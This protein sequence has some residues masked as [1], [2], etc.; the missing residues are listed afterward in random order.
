MIASLK[1]RFDRIETRRHAL[2]VDLMALPADQLAFRPAP[3]AWSLPEVAQHLS[4][5]DGRVTRVLTERRVTGVPRRTLRDVVI[6]ARMLDLFFLTGIRV[7]MPV[8]GVAPDSAVPLERTIEAWAA[9]RVVMAGY[10][11]TLDAPASRTIVYRHPV[12]GFMDIHDTLRFIER[13]H[14]HH[15]RQVARIR[16]TR[17]FPITVTAA[18]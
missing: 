3:G 13:H 5:V 12:G 1:D 6:R 9:S 2:C 11:E 16:A 15:L 18:S 10:L 8:K 4:L 17:G 7:K 14:D